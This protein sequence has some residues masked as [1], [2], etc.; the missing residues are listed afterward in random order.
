MGANHSNVSGPINTAVAFVGFVASF[1]GI[2][3]APA[4]TGQVALLCALGAASLGAGALSAT[5]ALQRR[6][7]LEVRGHLTP[8]QFDMSFALGHR[9]Y[10]RRLKKTYPTRQQA[11]GW[12]SNYSHGVFQAYDRNEYCWGYFSLWPLCESAFQRLKS[13]ELT[14]ADLVQTHIATAKDAPFTYWYIADIL[15]DDT[16]FHPNVSNSY[17]ADYFCHLMIYHALRGL[18]R[19]KQ[20]AFPFELVGCAVSRPGEKWL[21]RFQFQ[22]LLTPAEEK[23]VHKVYLRTL[24][25]KA[26]LNLLKQLKRVIKEHESEICRLT[27]NT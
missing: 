12:L 22:H 13:G 7:P 2:A 11:D 5:R 10:T 9:I 14:E 21:K 18:L 16:K 17:F 24:T 27:R 8:S 25:C 26:L 20:L 15:K 4:F 19:E 6:S 1:A 3:L 23:G